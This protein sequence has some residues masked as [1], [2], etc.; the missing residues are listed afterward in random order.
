MFIS[1]IRYKKKQKKRRNPA[2]GRCKNIQTQRLLP[3]KTPKVKIAKPCLE[4]K[5]K[6]SHRKV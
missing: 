6:P 3:P 4:R 2:T 5:K 1:M